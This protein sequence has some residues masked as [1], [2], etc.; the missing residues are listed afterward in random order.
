MYNLVRYVRSKIW[1]SG[2]MD[3]TTNLETGAT[4]EREF[5]RKC[6]F[7][8]ATPAIFSCWCSNEKKEKKRK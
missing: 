5:T 3:F 6:Q 2:K 1:K 8:A 7:V 4:E